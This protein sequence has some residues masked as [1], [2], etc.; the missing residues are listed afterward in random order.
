MRT[1]FWL[2]LLP[3]AYST[4]IALCCHPLYLCFLIVVQYCGSPNGINSSWKLANL[5]NLQMT[6]TF[7]QY[8]PAVLSVHAGSGGYTVQHNCPAPRELLTAVGS[9]LQVRIPNE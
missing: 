7:G 2:L 1:C 8:P 4:F 5:T 9:R 6:I 3:C